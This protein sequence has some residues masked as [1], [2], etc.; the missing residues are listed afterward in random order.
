M[1]L[2]SPVFISL[3]LKRF[4]SLQRSFIAKVR[5]NRYLE[6]S[7]VYEVEILRIFEVYRGKSGAHSSSNKIKKTCS[8]CPGKG[9]CPS[10]CR[11]NCPTVTGGH[12]NGVQL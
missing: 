11:L 2:L 4:F 1:L 10:E 9:E 7:C 12:I 3:Y 8:W 6:V 5:K